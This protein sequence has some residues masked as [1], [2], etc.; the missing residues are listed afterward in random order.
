MTWA[1]APLAA[2]ENDMRGQKWP[3]L[4]IFLGISPICLSKLLGFGWFFVAEMK[5]LRCDRDNVL[6]DNPQSSVYVLGAFGRL[7]SDAVGLS[8]GRRKPNDHIFNVV[9]RNESH[10]FASIAARASCMRRVRIARL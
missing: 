8:A 6:A 10:A 3:L 4:L 1:F 7:G 5:K 2:P 9:S